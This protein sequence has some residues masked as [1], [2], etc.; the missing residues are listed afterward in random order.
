[1][2]VF[3]VI[4]ENY[5]IKIS[6]LL[7][8]ISFLLLLMVP[9]IGVEIKGSQRWL[10]LPFIPRFQPIELIKPFYIVM[11]SLITSD[12]ADEPCGV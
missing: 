1:M 2:F 3:S 7:F 9:I 11:L 5:L 6:L 4:E 12:A 8:I 10:D